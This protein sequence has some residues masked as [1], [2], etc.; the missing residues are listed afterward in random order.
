MGKNKKFLLLV[1]LLLNFPLSFAQP[2]SIQASESK[3]QEKKAAQIRVEKVTIPTYPVGEEDPNPPFWTERSG[4]YPYPMQT[5]ITATKE[6]RIYNTIVMGNSYIRLIVLPELGGRLLGAHDRTNNG[7]DFL[8]HNHV[9]KPG[10]I[11][12]RGAWLSGGIE[13]NFPTLGHTV[14]TVSPVHY[15]IQNNP[16]GS[17][18][19]IV[20]EIEFVRRMWWSVS[21]TIYPDRSYI[22]VVPTVYNRTLLENNGYFWSN[23]AVH[24][25]DDCQVI[26]GHTRYVKPWGGGQPLNW[27]VNNGIDISW[28]KN[29]PHAADFFCGELE[30]FHGAYYHDKNCGTVHYGNRYESSGKKFFTWGT[31]RSGRI[32]EDILTDNDGQYIEIQAG[33]LR[34]MAY[35]WIF[36][37]RMVEQWK[38]YWYPVK[39]MGGFVQANPEAALNCEV[40]D[41]KDIFLALNVTKT[42]LQGTLELTANGKKLYSEEIK[43]LS[44]GECW[45][46]TISLEEGVPPT[47]KVI[48]H[49]AK[50]EEIIH[51]QRKPSK[52]WKAESPTNPQKSESKMTGAELYNRGLDMEKDW[53]FEEM[54]RLYSMSVE[55]DPALIP[56]HLRLGLYLYKKGEYS[57]ALNHF[58]KAVELRKPGSFEDDYPMSRYLRA[59]T[60]L[61]MEREEEAIKDLW[62]CRRRRGFNYLASY[63]LGKISLRKSDWSQAEGFLRESIKENYQDYKAQGMLI[64]VLRREDKIKEARDRLTLLLEGNP[65]SPLAVAENYFL[66]KTQQAKNRLFKF[67]SRS[68]QDALELSIDYGNAGF[69]DEAIMILE[70]FESIPE[71]TNPLFSGKKKE[72]NPMI[73][74]YKGYYYQLKGDQAKAK[75]AFNRGFHL[76][77]D[78][79]F[80][81]RLE[82][83]NVLYLTLKNNPRDWKA[84]YYL[85]N[86]FT[87]K[88]RWEEGFLAYQRA[89]RIHPSFSVLH[90]NIAQILWKKKLIFKE[91]LMDM[92]KL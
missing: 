43:N 9:I 74:Y 19:C 30:D 39:N 73:L 78:Y 53:N 40:K 33:R 11:G 82:S 3:F 13:W 91:Q 46:K 29:I 68:F 21:L 52:P 16:D 38:E 85:G 31:A 80:P 41:K 83:F 67:L 12:L 49:S 86:L 79:V 8:Y 45:N 22:E 50:G 48:I 65:I 5:N 59:L 15:S 56:A 7:M 57:Q 20:G 36:E 1:F 18:T 42:L 47:F 63:L 61:K 44:P 71:K 4:V 76:S 88:S 10:L 35:S 24:A 92:K 90:R 28:Y 77:P 66:N 75:K 60:L 84:L 27:P 89:E 58:D 34:N 64:A 51:Y 23:A 72:I 2:K 26:F 37:P 32:W 62:V 14:S 70:T 55:K 81:S 25:T 54:A 87:S 17:V 6:D 69:Y